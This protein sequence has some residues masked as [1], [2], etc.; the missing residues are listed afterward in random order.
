VGDTRGPVTTAITMGGRTLLSRVFHVNLHRVVEQ[1]SGAVASNVGD[2]SHVV[3]RAAVRWVSLFVRNFEMTLYWGATWA[4]IHVLVLLLSG[5]ILSPARVPAALA[6][7]ADL[8]PGGMFAISIARLVVAITRVRQVDVFAGAP[9]ARMLPSG[10]PPRGWLLIR[11]LQPTDIDV[12]VVL[13]LTLIVG[14]LATR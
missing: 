4:V 3:A 13:A 11:L 12:L 7:M 6:L 10:D 9:A 8:F 2:D 5:D 14:V 1:V